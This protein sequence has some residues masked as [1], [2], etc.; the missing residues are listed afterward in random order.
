VSTPLV[1]K[2]GGS[3]A[4]SGRLSAMLCLVARATTPV[5]IVPGG[6]PFAD[7]VRA[8]Q[9]Q[10]QLTDRLSHRLALLSMHQMGHVL[11]AHDPRFVPAETPADISRILAA[12]AIPVWLPFALQ[13]DDDTLPADWTATSDALAARLAER[14][15]C[16]G[17]ALVKSC[18]IA[19]DATLAEVTTHGIVDPVFAHVVTRAQLAWSLYGA[20]DDARLVARLSGDGAA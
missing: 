11:A 3:L 13:Q 12:G 1:L 17:V 19:L 2:L 15:R 9:P 4:E 20:G 10:L 16:G 7:A 5:V 6:G 8:I 14:L 18:A